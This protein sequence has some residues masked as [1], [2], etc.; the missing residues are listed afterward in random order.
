VLGLVAAEAAH[1]HGEP[2]RQALL[3]VLR[4]HRR[5]LEER[6]AN[7]PGV[8]MSP[9]QSTY[10]AWLDLREAHA[11]ERL[12][13]PPQRLL[14]ERAGV[15]LSDGADFGWPGFARLNFGTTAKQLEAALARLDGVLRQ[16]Q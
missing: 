10:L 16:T 11:L 14:L 8:A 12:S 7:W 6:V 4:G 2:W 9:P 3:E 15:A 5:T 13:G 1:A